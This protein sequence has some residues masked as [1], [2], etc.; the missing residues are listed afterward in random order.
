MKKRGF[1]KNRYFIDKN[2]QKKLNYLGKITNM[3]YNK[4]NI[5]KRKCTH[6]GGISMFGNKNAGSKA[7]TGSGNT[8]EALEKYQKIYVNGTYDGDNWF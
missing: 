3:Y 5:Y 6:K 2:I 8:G 7:H 4:G 1:I